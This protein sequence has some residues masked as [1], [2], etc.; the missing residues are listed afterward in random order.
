QIHRT[1]AAPKEVNKYL[2]QHSL[3]LLKYVA[4]YCTTCYSGAVATLAEVF[5]SKAKLQLSSIRVLNAQ[6]PADAEAPESPDH[7]LVSPSGDTP[8]I[9][10]GNGEVSGC[11]G[12]LATAS[13]LANV[14]I[15]VLL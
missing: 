11:Q 14:M 10:D 3:Q 12:E 4:T 9:S 8:E 6:L 13:K 7:P 5:M 2:K 15:P 1:A